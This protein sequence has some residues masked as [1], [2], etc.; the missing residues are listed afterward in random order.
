MKR[1]I[2]TRTVFQWDDK[3]QR[4][5]LEK[6]E[7]YWYDGPMALAMDSPTFRQDA[8]QLFNDNGTDETD[9]TSKAGVGVDITGQALDENILV[10]F[11]V[12]ETAGN[13]QANYKPQLQIRLNGGTYQSVDGV[14][15]IGRSS[16]SPVLVDGEDTTQRLGSGTFLTVNEGVDEVNGVAGK[17]AM[18]FVGNDETEFVYCFQVRSADVSGGDNVE[19][20]ISDATIDV[21]GDPE[22]KITLAVGGPTPFVGQGTLGNVS[23]TGFAG[24]AILNVN[25]GFQFPDTDEMTGDRGVGD[26]NWA[27]VANATADDGLDTFCVLATGETS[28]GLECKNFAFSIPAGATITGVEVQIG[29]YSDLLVDTIDWL[30]IRLILS[31]DTDGTENKA[32]AMPDL[33]TGDITGVVGGPNDLWSETLN[34]S[35]VQDFDFGCSI[36]VAEEGAGGTVLID[37][38]RMRVFYTTGAGFIG[39]GTAGH[40]ILDD[41]LAGTIIHGQADLQGTLGNVGVTGFAGTFDNGATPFVDQGTLGNVT[42]TGFAGEFQTDFVGQGT[43]G[44]VTVTGFA[45]TVEAGFALAGT[46]GSV[47]VTGNISTIQAGFT[48]AGTAGTVTVTGFAGTL[49]AMDIDLRVTFPTPPSDPV[50]AQRFNIRVRRDAARTENGE[51]LLSAFLYEGGVQRGGALVTDVPIT[52][53]VNQLITADWLASALVTTNGSDVECR[54]T[55]TPVNGRSADIGHIEWCAQVVGGAAGFTG[56]GTAGNVSVTGGVGSVAAGF[57]LQG[58]SGALTVT[59]LAGAIVHGNVLQGTLGNLTVTGLAGGLN[60]GDIIQGPEGHVAVSGFAGQFQTQFIGQGTAGSVTVTGFAGSVSAG[61]TLQGTA[62]NVTVT[63]GAGTIE[64]G[65]V[66]QGTEG[67]LSITGFA[68]TVDFGLETFIG[69]GTAGTLSVTGNVATIIHGHVVQGTLANVGVTGFA[70]EF[71]A[72]FVGQGTAG[73]VTVTGFAGAVA[74]GHVLQGAAGN[75][76]ITGFAGILQ[77]GEILQGTLGQVTITGL[78][79]AVVHGQILQGTLATLTVT[80]FAGSITEGDIL[81]GITGHLTVSG[82]AG[83]LDIGAPNFG[84]IEKPG[85]IQIGEFYELVLLDSNDLVQIG[86]EYELVL[87]PESSKSLVQIGNIYSLKKIGEGK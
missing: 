29:D 57:T 36:H 53:D 65:L 58:T 22:I 61:F 30:E 11:L 59:G 32:A 46:A 72:P 48:L 19:V 67:H 83:G 77:S 80:G 76:P 73:N 25:T 5:L 15:T 28:K 44:N 45:G 31:G 75:L 14:S 21:Y 62:G 79:G 39:Q 16:A 13:P 27:T 70:G 4:F 68:G 17:N 54:I 55:V 12:Q 42:V 18:N 2:S 84:D 40:L 81:Q 78:A 6:K 33:E 47:T 26:I 7:G 85:I 24:T 49:S 63:G 38:V 3:S 8:I 86:D 74:H 51:S 60:E 69:Q 20:R 9:S 34:R 87:I 82:F 52:D 56:Q 41:A 1:F 37:F 23:V 50:D 64:A 35:D 10:R 43:L 66:V 71:Q